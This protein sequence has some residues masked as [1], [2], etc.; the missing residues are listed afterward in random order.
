MSEDALGSIEAYFGARRPGEP[1]LNEGRIPAGTEVVVAGLVVNHAFSP[2]RPIILASIDHPD[3]YGDMAVN[4]RGRLPVHQGVAALCQ[5][6]AGIALLAL[7]S[8]FLATVLE[9]LLDRREQARAAAEQDAS[10]LAPEP[11]G[12]RS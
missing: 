5:A 8:A 1:F 2:R 7:L 11:S 10:A 12:G 4:L 3:L 9:A 6:G